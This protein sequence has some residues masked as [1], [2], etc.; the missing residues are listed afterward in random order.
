[1]GKAHKFEL[2]AFDFDGTLADSSQNIYAAA[3]FAFDEFGLPYPGD[4]VIGD[5]VGLELLDCA[6]RWLPEGASFGDIQ[7]MAQLYKKGFVHVRALDDFHEPLFDGVK[8]TLSRLV[9]EAVFMGVCTGKNRQGLQHMLEYHGIGD[10]FATLQTPDTNAGKPSPDM[11]NSAMRETGK[12]PETTVVIGDTSYDMLMARAAGASA[13]GVAY[14]H[15]SSD[16]LMQAGAQ[17][18]IPH[19]NALDDA[20]AKLSNMR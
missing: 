1:M 5:T 4:P 3:R 16:A 14:G 10:Y 7:T 19:M 13:I 15:H 8:D 20:L 11:V 12:D 18:I 2:L 9:D 17:I 6:Q